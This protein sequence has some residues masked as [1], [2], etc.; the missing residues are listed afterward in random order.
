MDPDVLPMPWKKSIAEGDGQSERLSLAIL[1][2]DGV[3][4]PH[5]PIVAALKEAEAA[6]V[7]A[8]HEVIRWEPLDDHQYA[9]D[10]LV[11]HTIDIHGLY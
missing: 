11:Y 3:V 7:A 9:W 6:L 5:P 10:L 2:D 1:W 4:A 8:G